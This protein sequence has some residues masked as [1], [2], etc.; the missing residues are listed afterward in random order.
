MNSRPVVKVTC[1][2]HPNVPMFSTDSGC[3]SETVVFVALPISFDLCVMVG[4]EI[5]GAE[6]SGNRGHQ[7]RR[8]SYSDGTPI[9]PELLLSAFSSS[10]SNICGRYRTIHFRR[11][12]T[13]ARSYSLPFS[14]STLSTHTLTSLSL[15]PDHTRSHTLSYQFDLSRLW[16]AEDLM[17]D[18][19]LEQNEDEERRDNDDHSGIVP[20]RRSGGGGRAERGDGEEWDRSR[21]TSASLSSHTFSRS[22]HLTQRDQDAIE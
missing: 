11:H 16:D 22:R 7:L 8:H 13:P 21:N 10:P 17:M 18:D 3:C 2:D 14:I 12:E 19:G 20:I 1:S 15:S 5:G 9:S 6:E 4:L